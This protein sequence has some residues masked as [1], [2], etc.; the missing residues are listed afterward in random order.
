[1]ISPQV[2]ESFVAPYDS[3]LI[4]TAHDVLKMLMAG[5]DVTMMASALLRHGPDWIGTVVDGLRTWIDEHDYDSVEQ[6]KGSMSQAAI[7]D[8]SALERANYMQS[9]ITYATPTSRW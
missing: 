5:A 3:E 2:F 8:P 1:M 7:P 6:L 4:A 9:L